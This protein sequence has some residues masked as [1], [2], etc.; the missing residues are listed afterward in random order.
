MLPIVFQ[1]VRLRNVF[2]KE[3]ATLDSM[4]WAEY[5]AFAYSQ[6]FRRASVRN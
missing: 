5:Y 3:N 6:N 2:P 1:S 4:T